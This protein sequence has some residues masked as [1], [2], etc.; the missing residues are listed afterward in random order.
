MGGERG[1]VKCLSTPTQPATIIRSTAPTGF[2][3]GATSFRMTGSFSSNGFRKEA[4]DA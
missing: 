4:K 2:Q 1:P 3:S